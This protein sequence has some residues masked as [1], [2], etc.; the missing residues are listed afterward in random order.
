MVLLE[1]ASN[2]AQLILNDLFPELSH[3]HIHPI[4]STDSD[5]FSKLLVQTIHTHESLLLVQSEH[6]AAKANAQSLSAASLLIQH[7]HVLDQL[8]ETIDR[9]LHGGDDLCESLAETDA[10]ADQKSTL[11]TDCLS[12]MASELHRQGRLIPFERESLRTFKKALGDIVS[13]IEL[14]TPALDRG[15][16]DLQIM[17]LAGSYS[18][19]AAFT[20][21]LK[22]IQKE[23]LEYRDLI[24][25][26]VNMTSLSSLGTP[27]QR[28]KHAPL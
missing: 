21:K 4:D 13:M 9:L 7:R 18:R 25:P 6:R 11:G 19:Q 16:Q 17:G 23:I 8:Y 15:K 1:S 5:V 14:W 24:S 22:Q 10:D 2:H 28:S 27:S 3:N 26:V 12:Q 20:E